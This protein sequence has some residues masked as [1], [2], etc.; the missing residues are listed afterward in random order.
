MSITFTPDDYQSWCE[1]EA[2]W[3]SACL[4]V[5]QDLH[6]RLWGW[7]MLYP[8]HRRRILKQNLTDRCAWLRN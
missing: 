4:P 1:E 8:E 6:E 3:L 2:R 7:P 5:D